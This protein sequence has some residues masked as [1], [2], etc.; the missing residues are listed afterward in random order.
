MIFRLITV[1]LAIIIN[2]IVIYFIESFDKNTKSKDNSSANANFNAKANS[3]TTNS[4]AL[5]LDLDLDLDSYSITKPTLLAEPC[6]CKN[7]GD[8]KPLFIKY[9]SVITIALLVLIYFVPLFLK[10]IR[11]NNQAI[12]LGNTIKSPVGSFLLSIFIAVGFFNIF[13]LF[14]YTKEKESELCNC[15]TELQEII[16][17]A[18]MYYS[19]FVLLIYIVTTVVTFALRK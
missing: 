13:F 1:V 2:L 11:L 9:Y 14:R 17:Q 7:N 3:N 8:F 12:S 6:V 5:N 10:I 16:R 15:K 19:M 18:L 4:P